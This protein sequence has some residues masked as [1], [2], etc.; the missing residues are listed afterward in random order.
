MLGAAKK[1]KDVSKP[2]AYKDASFFSKDWGLLGGLTMAW[3]C[4]CSGMAEE[5]VGW[6]VYRASCGTLW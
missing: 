1:Q 2:G 6:D 4:P 5:P 3:G